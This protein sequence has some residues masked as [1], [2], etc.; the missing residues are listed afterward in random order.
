MKWQGAAPLVIAS[1]LA[2]GPAWAGD[3]P[4][5][6]PAPAWVTPA[7]DVLGKD[8]QKSG[9]FVPLFDQ[10]V[11]IDGDTAETYVDTAYLIASAEALNQRGTLTFP[12]QPDHGDLTVHKVEIIRGD[13]RINALAGDPGFTVLRREAGLERLSVDGVLTAVK[14]VEGLRV[15][16]ILHFSVSISERDK[17]LKGNA[18]AGMVVVPKPV[19]IGFGRAR[20]I[21]PDSERVAVKALMPGIDVTPKP[22]AGGMEEIS[23]PL[24]VPTLPEMPK[25][26]P[27]R[28]TPLPLLIASTFKS[29]EDVSAVMAPYYTTKGAIA[30]GSDLARV[31]D[32]IAARTADPV[33][34]IAAALQ[35]V[36][37]D[38][39]YQLIALG[40]G[41]YVPQAPADTWQKRFGDCKAKT[42]LL[43]AMLDR[44]GIKAEPVLAN[45]QRGDAVTLMPPAAMAFDHVFVR[46]EVKG[47]SFWLDGTSLGARLADVRDVPRFGKVLPIRPG[48]AA[49]LDLPVRAKARF[50]TDAELTLDNTAGP[51]LPAPFTLKVKYAGATAA[52]VRVKEGAN[53]AE[54]LKTFAEKLSKTWADSTT[55]AVPTAAYDPTD[56]TWT[57]TVDG[58]AYP[59]WNYI[60]G[61]YEMGFKP[62]IKVVFDPDRSRSAWR[63]IPA[64]IDDPWTARS[65]YELKLVDGGKGVT[66]EGG[67]PAHLNLP[68]VTWQR[69]IALQGGSVVEAVESHESG[70]EVPPADIGSTK[71][72]I[73]ELMD[74]EGRIKLPASYPQRWDDVARRRAAPAL[75]RVKAVFDQRIADKPDDAVR[76]EDRGWLS[77]RLL[78]WKAAEADY[79]K[80]IALDASP[81][82]YVKRARARS[83]LG[84]HAGALKDAQAAYDIDSSN[85]DARAQLAEELAIAGKVDQALD[86]LEGKPD[87]A[88]EDGQNA[89]MESVDVLERG[90]RHDQALTILDAAITKRPSVASLR[91][92][93]CWYQGLRNQSLDTALADC[94]K[95]IELA[96]DPA[97]YLDSRAMVHYRAGRLTEAL[98]D[99]D[100]A[101]AMSPE[102]ASSHFMKG[103]IF[104][105]QGK[106]ADAQ[107]EL[108]AARKLYPDIEAYLGVFG[109]RPH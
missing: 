82:R 94:N 103:V 97:A 71:R 64:L 66:L 29:W 107:R 79:S 70:L 37:E 56:A 102:L 83:T 4:L 80:A 104:G 16:D 73:A 8:S 99:L 57:V 5:V 108:A 3:K 69:T 28:F 7:P 38:V 6:A 86:L 1:I 12:W 61:H 75:A 26:M 9:V 100:G 92:A 23:I 105:Q 42:M 59:T 95:A 21:W 20:L 35:T 39:R 27:V 13:E 60:D 62:L 55:I 10:Q 47:E 89:A 106:G 91:N 90:G 85:K 101:L 58:V 46:A 34:R 84:D 17:V 77:E 63:Q 109:I 78:D 76:L 81:D 25:A 15:G 19:Q 30:E 14:H 48:G 65:R 49:L 52:Q 32:G 43:I 44:M 72:T 51:H 11:R 24:P 18:Q 93:R 67:D 54:E 53:S 50:G 45:S 36:Q 74:R 40:T 41:N 31:V 88:T 98:S 22:L 68:A 33:E 87:L 96:S 2:A